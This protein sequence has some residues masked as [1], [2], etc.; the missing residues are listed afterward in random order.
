VGLCVADLAMAIKF[1]TALGY[2]EGDL[3]QEPG[4]GDLIEIQ[5]VVVHI[6]HRPKHGIELE[7][8]QIGS[9][10]APGIPVRRAMHQQ[11]MTHLALR[12]DDVDRVAGVVQENGGT[13]VERTRTTARSGFGAEAVFCTDPDGARILLL[14]PGEVV[15]LPTATAFGPAGITFS[16]FG[17]CVADVAL[18]AQFYKSFGFDV[19]PIQDRGLAFSGFAE[20]GDTPLT[21]CLI[22]RGAYAFELM[23]WGRARSPG[24]PARRSIA[25]QGFTHIGT[26]GSDLAGQMALF[27]AIGGTVINNAAYN[28]KGTNIQVVFC[29]DPDGTRIELVG[30]VKA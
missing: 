14:G 18:S 30:P 19:A 20:V 7:L 1:Y 11:G 2:D 15:G 29:T 8:L 3:V 23:Q 16:H 22:R 12:V 28:V 6:S 13:V 26:S 4:L 25:Q 24:V 17:I 27:K 5:D 10:R 9:A 21:S